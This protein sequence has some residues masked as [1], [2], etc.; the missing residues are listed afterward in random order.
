MKD[1]D[2]E[3]DKSFGFSR[4]AV[5]VGQK[6]FEEGKIPKASWESFFRIH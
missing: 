2:F 5:K 6:D 1:K 3:E 4:V